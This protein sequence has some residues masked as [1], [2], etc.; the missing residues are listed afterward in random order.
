MLHVLVLRG[1]IF[2]MDMMP[3]VVQYVCTPYNHSSHT[4]IKACFYLIGFHRCASVRLRNFLWHLLRACPSMATRLAQKCAIT[5]ER[6]LLIK[7]I[8]F[9][10]LYL[11]KLKSCNH[12][13]VFLKNFVICICCLFM[14]C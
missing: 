2:V 8:M 1:K 4:S 13:N 9:H 11:A 5:D 7:I 12:Q 6:D 10:G 3:K 14:R